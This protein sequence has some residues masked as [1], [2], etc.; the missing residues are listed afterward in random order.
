MSIDTMTWLTFICLA[1]T[2]LFTFLKIRK[3]SL[4]SAIAALVIYIMANQT[5][6]YLAIASLKNLGQK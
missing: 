2:V 5:F 3:L 6:F 1:L 4:I